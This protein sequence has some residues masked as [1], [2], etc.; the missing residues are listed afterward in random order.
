MFLFLKNKI[1]NLVKFAENNNYDLMNTNL[2]DLLKLLINDS[3]YKQ[4]DELTKNLLFELIE[5][6]FVKINLS[7]SL[8]INNKYSHFLKRASD[9]KKFNLD[10][11]SL[12]MEF[13]DDILN[14]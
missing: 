12:F 6:Y 11:E 8:N 4:K 14:G 5:L 9:T 1:Y 2:K 10:E 3:Q 13:K 7:F